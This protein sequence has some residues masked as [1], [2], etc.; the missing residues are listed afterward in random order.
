M[1]H[2]H[3]ND[4]VDEDELSDEDEDDEEDGSNDTADAAVLNTVIRRVAVLS[5]RVLRRTT[6]VA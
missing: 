3:G 4:D 1:F 5:Q 6:P 2:K